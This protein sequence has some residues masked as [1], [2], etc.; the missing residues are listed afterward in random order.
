MPKKIS[1][2][3][4]REWFNSY[5][6]GQAEAKIASKAKHDV[7][8]IKSGIEEVKRERDAQLARSELLRDAL[9]KHQDQMLS[10]IDGIVNALELPA[11][12]LSVDVPISLKE[13]EI[14]YEKTKGLDLILYSEKKPEWGL[15][16]EHIGKRDRL[17]IALD[18]WKRTVIS[19]MHLRRQLYSELEE[20]LKDKGYE[21]VENTGIAPYLYRNSVWLLYRDVVKGA[22]KE[23]AKTD[24]TKLIKIHRETGEVHYGSG[25]ILAKA[26]REEEKCRNN[27]LDALDELG[28]KSTV[29][30]LNETCKEIETSI[31]ELNITA[32]E[33]S[34]IGLIPGRCQVCRRIGI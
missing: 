34:L 9:R 30:E 2:V 23:K 26:P 17:W 19:H 18:K 10:C 16:K 32:V 24:F 25:I 11:I 20:L 29:G 22:L 1:I 4:K 8:T 7:K 6:N 28:K 13:A 14:T 27:V 15:L 33:F 12:D 5:E 31:S 3:Q 21:L